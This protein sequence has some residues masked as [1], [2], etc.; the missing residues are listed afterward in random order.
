MNYLDL[1]SLW[2]NSVDDPNLLDELKAMD[3]KED[4][5]KDRFYKTLAFGTGGLRGIL[6]AGTNRMNIYTVAQA[7]QGFADYLND[8]FTNPAVAIANDSR[9]MSSDFAICTAIVFAANGIKVNIF[10]DIAPTP[11]LSYAVR[12]LNCQGG[13]VVT[14]SHNPAIYNGYKAYNDKGCQITADIA[15][16]VI[17]NIGKTDIF[18]GVKTIKMEDA[19]EK[20]LV[21]YIG[22]ELIEEY[23]AD[24]VKAQYRPEITADSPLEVVYTPLNGAGYKICPALLD[25]I[26]IKNLHIVEEQS[27]PDGNF[28]T[29]PYPNPEMKEALQLGIEKLKATNAH[30]LLATD[31]DADR[32]GVAVKQGEDIQI[33]TGD[34]VGLLLLN[35]VMVSAKEL[36][37]AEKPLVAIKSIVSSKMA[38]VI[39]KA[40][41]GRI[42]SVLTGFKNIGEYMDILEAEG[43]EQ[44][45]FAYEESCGYLSHPLIRDKDAPNA[46]ALFTEMAAWYL[47]MGKTVVDGLNEL[48]E[49]HGYY[50]SRSLSYGFEGFSGEEVMKGIMAELREGKLPQ[51]SKVKIN[52][53]KDYLTGKV[54]GNDYTT[55]TQPLPK[56][57]M[58]EFIL[59]GGNSFMVR[60]SGTEPKMKVYYFTKHKDKAVAN[61]QF[62]D[63]S[64]FVG[65]YIKS[66]QK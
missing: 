19:I 63:I 3:K 14:A 24:L 22:E 50:I 65:D 12:K 32:V 64:K 30:I 46:I 61:K 60:P 28:P 42:K 51:S 49:E 8:N 37:L 40:H 41:G 57:D 36:G 21:N 15:D 25:T 13:V 33:L 16:Q 29:C 39:T 38:D 62:K 17:K 56:T 34:E 58:V 7:T 23:K 47:S 35:Y 11:L 45:I 52:L 1:Y 9:N 43:K 55:A 31:P 10:R 27:Q 26:G 54:V 66:K 48:Y 44:F 2:L 59:E 18:T 20:G 6:G 53:T 4:E 5:I